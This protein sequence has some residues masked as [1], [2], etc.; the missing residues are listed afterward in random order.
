MPARRRA[1]TFPEI[2]D[3]VLVTLST[4]GL[5]KAPPIFKQ[6]EV[7][8][9]DGLEALKQLVK[10]GKADQWPAIKAYKITVR[11]LEAVAAIGA[12]TDVRF[13]WQWRKNDR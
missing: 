6:A 1:L 12:R 13:Q 8:V 4:A 7:P 3:R 5:T 2:S 10:D 11:G 9:K